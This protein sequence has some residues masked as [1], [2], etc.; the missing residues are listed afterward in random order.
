M[1]SL[2]ETVALFLFGIS[3]PIA[4]LLGIGASILTPDEARARA[5]VQKALSIPS[6]VSSIKALVESFDKLHVGERRAFGI[7][8]ESE[9]DPK[10]KPQKRVLLEF[11]DAQVK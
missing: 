10:D 7:R 8:D 6:R 3:M 1:I 2:S 5:A 9:D 11:I 4:D